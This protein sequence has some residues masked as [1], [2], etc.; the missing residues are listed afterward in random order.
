VPTDNVAY[1]AFISY[2]REDSEQVD[3][4]ERILE[5]AY[6]PVWRDTNDLWPGQDW[7]SKIREAIKN[8]ALAFI[9]CFSSN[10]VGKPKTFMNE[11]LVLAVEQIRLMQPGHVWLIPVR[12]DDCQL[13][14]YDL[15][16]GRTLESIQRID[17]FGPKREE[18]ISR[19]VRA[20][21]G[22][23]GQSEL[24]PA[25]EAEAIPGADAGDRGALLAGALKG[26]L[27]DPTRQIEVENLISAEVR[28]EVEN[29]NDSTRFPLANGNIT[30]RG[31][32][33]RARDY[34][35]VVEPAAYAATVLGA[36]GRPEHAPLVTRMIDA[37]AKTVHSELA[38][39]T[40]T[41]SEMCGLGAADLGAGFV[42]PL[43]LGGQR[44]VE[45]AERVLEADDG[46]AAQRTLR[47]RQYPPGATSTCRW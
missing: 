33:E 44:S 23:L 8:G 37:L 19:V 45:G 17:L 2:V 29:L 22:V 27:S 14:E 18:N 11:E 4:L 41:T 25:T 46:L 42:D 20:V 15:G 26:A 13:L 10:S 24:S 7:K 1:H 3:S 47:R 30:E 40:V 35:S 12:L 28:A 32:A 31:L 43:A 34:D 16:A 38:G 21:L 39:S 9:A 5:A 6:L 36:W